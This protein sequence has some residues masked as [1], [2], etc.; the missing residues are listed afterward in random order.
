MTTAT[1]SI[2]VKCRSSGCGCP[3]SMLEKTSTGATNRATWMLLLGR[4]GFFGATEQVAVRAQREDQAQDVGTQEDPRDFLA[5]QFDALVF[6]GV[7]CPRQLVVERR[8][9]QADRR[10]RQQRR[11]HAGRRS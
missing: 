9:H 1:T 3:I 8:Q 2:S 10:Q 11:P 7:L 5:E 6:R 4:R